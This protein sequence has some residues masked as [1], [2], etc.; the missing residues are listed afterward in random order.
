MNDQTAWAMFYAT[1]VGMAQHPGYK[2]NQGSNPV[3][4][5]AHALTADAML[6]EYQ[7]RFGEKPC[8]SSQAYLSQA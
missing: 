1:I 4:L 7:Q 3:A 5:A 6:V 8:L 2:T